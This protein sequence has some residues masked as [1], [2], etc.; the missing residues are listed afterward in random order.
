MLQ[1]LI[2]FC[3]NLQNICL[4]A[5][6]DSP[7]LAALGLGVLLTSAFPPFYQ[8]WVIFPALAITLYLCCQT[9]DWKRII[10]I[11]YWFGFGFFASGFYWIGNA[12]LVDIGKTGWMYPIALFL[13][14]AFFGLFMIF[15][16]AFTK[17]V[18][19][20]ILNKIKIFS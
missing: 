19:N 8:I 20:I 12:L 14:G 4:K 9:S 2:K 11:G 13:N 16:F 7:K 6:L 17:L 15:P 18:K 5:F 3:V 1:K 10:G